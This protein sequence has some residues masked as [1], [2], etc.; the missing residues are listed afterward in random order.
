LDDILFSV[1]ENPKLLKTITRNRFGSLTIKIRSLLTG[2]LNGKNE[3]VERMVNAFDA[4]Y[5]DKSSA[6]LYLKAYFAFQCRHYEQ[7]KEFSQRALEIRPKAYPVLHLMGSIAQNLIKNE[8]AVRWYRLALEINPASYTS[9]MNLAMLRSGLCDNE[10]A[11]EHLEAI[12]RDYPNKPIVMHNYGLVLARAGDFLKALKTYEKNIFPTMKLVN[13]VSGYYYNCLFAIDEM[14]EDISEKHKKIGKHASNAFPAKPFPLQ[15]SKR[16]KI[17][18]GY[19]SGDFKRHSCA[20]FLEPIIRNHSDS[21]E[22]HCLSL[23]TTKDKITAH[24]A[25]ICDQFHHLEALSVKR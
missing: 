6:L 25:N 4:T 23:T 12:A 8:E 17:K 5:V 18:V 2:F 11:L 14:T 1:M 24:F 9:R 19:L 10:A 7:A 21:F 15:Q 3:Q 22:T 16:K 13:S 20:F